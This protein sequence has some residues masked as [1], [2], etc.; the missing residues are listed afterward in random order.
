MKRII[1]S[2]LIASSLTLAL[3]A[4][5]SKGAPYSPKT[6]DNLDWSTGWYIGAGFNSDAEFLLKL[7]GTEDITN[8]SAA[9]IEMDS[10]NTG[11][12]VYLG[13]EVNPYF[14][15]EFGYT[16]VGNL[17]LTGKTDGELVEK[18]TVRQWN[19]HV[20]ALA[21]APVG[22]HLNFFLKG[23]VTWY[24]NSQKVRDYEEN[25]TEHDK[26]EG[27]ALTYGA[28]AEVAWDQF[29]LRADYT[30]VRPGNSISKDFYISDLVGMSLIYK[31][32]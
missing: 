27:V 30:K 26:S 3:P 5:A 9:K 22:E 10:H 31:F 2:S 17:D 14:T 15:T 7:H 6:Q 13:R 21:K 16:Y 19:L 4:L 8:I 12:D 29:A 11:F 20:V 1:L 18:V 23:G 25:T 28:G 24:N 32:M